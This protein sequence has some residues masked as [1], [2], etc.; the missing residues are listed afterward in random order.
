MS[1]LRIVSRI[2]VSSTDLKQVVVDAD[3]YC[4]AGDVNRNGQILVE[5]KLRPGTD[6]GQSRDCAARTA[7]SSMARMARTSGKASVLGIRASSPAS[8]NRDRRRQSYFTTT[9]SPARPKT[10]PPT[11]RSQ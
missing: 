6:H 2:R 3:L 10:A 4:K 8:T 11:A 1:I 5:R 9:A 7:H